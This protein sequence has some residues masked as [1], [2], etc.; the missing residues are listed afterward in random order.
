MSIDHATA[1]AKRIIPAAG[2]EW[3]LSDHGYAVVVSRAADIIRWEIGTEWR[4]IETAPKDGTWILGWSACDSI[5]ARISWGRNHNGELRWCTSFCSFIDGYI[6]HWI[7]M[8][9]LLPQEEE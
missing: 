8:P 7:P 3:P 9:S 2:S 6:T 5:P 1:I 4:P